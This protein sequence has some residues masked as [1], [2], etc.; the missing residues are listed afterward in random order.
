MDFNAGDLSLIFKSPT[1]MSEWKQLCIFCLPVGS[2]PRG[3]KD[4]AHSAESVTI[5]MNL[6]KEIIFKTKFPDTWEH[7]PVHLARFYEIQMKVYSMIP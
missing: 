1:Y 4:F 7:C 6:N 5:I 3:Y 2:I